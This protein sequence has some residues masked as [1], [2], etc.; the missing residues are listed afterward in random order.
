M[1]KGLIIKGLLLGI[2]SSILTSL[3]DSLYMFAPDIYVPAAYPF[4]LVFFNI[5]FWAL[6]GGLCGFLMWLF[7]GRNSNFQMKEPL[8]W[9][10]FFLAPFMLLYG[11]LG[12]A[13]TV[14]GSVLEKLPFVTPSYSFFWAALVLL[15]LMICL[16]KS[17]APLRFSPFSFLLEILLIILLFQ[18]SANI[19]QI[20][21]FSL[22]YASYEEFFKSIGLQRTG[23]L[24]ILYFAGLTGLFCF[25]GVAFFKIRPYFAR[26]NIPLSYK[27]TA[28]VL[29]ILIVLL[30][31]LVT[32]IY[33]TTGAARHT[34]SPASTEQRGAKTAAPVILI[35][36]DTVRADHL[37]LY[38]YN[39]ANKNLEAFSKDALVFDAC[40]ANSCWTLPSHAS[41]FTGLYPNEHGAHG[42]LNRKIIIGDFE[43]DPLPRPL[44]E[45]MITLAEIFKENGYQTMAVVANNIV[46]GKDMNMYQGFDVYECFGNIGDLNRKYPFRPIL[47]FI[48]YLANV[49]DFF[50]NTMRA[51]QIT[52]RC[53]Q[54]TAG[55]FSAPV[56]LFVNYMDAHEA[57]CP[58]RPYHS[59][60]CDMRFPHLWRLQM[61]F[62]KRMLKRYSQTTWDAYAKTQYDGAIAYLDDQLGR[63]F[64]HLKQSNLYDP[65]LIIVTSDH[66]ELFGE[67]GFRGHRT[68]MYEGVLR[69]PLIIKFPYSK[70][71][72]RE[73]KEI[74]L[75]DVFSTILS[76]CEIPMPGNVSG[77]PFGNSS[78]PAVAEYE[79]A[80]MGQHRVLYDGQYKYFFYE[81]ERPAELYDLRKDPSENDNL[82]ENQPAV[83][84]LLEEKLKKWVISHPPR[85][86]SKDSALSPETVDGLK[87]LGYIQ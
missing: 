16:A 67:H 18:F 17:V 85:Y 51:G 64:A 7:V 55:P 71:V 57:Y 44:D 59:Y 40:I 80:L 10:V 60:Y 70:Q 25:Y 14:V 5:S 38:G 3:F 8:Y 27:K 22:P 63:F 50:M 2:I 19:A 12:L 78:S 58:P 30:A 24:L 68:P 33:E 69:V 73:K 31:G 23:Y 42:D 84:K 65:A 11:F 28:A 56:F 13:E 62:R 81:R 66:G 37:S 35:V 43:G 87:A 39:V 53:K 82:A 9:T 61:D 45:K 15:F 46:L 54:L 36:L 48:S 74:Q 75:S 6:I 20:K 26:K 76:I 49:P 52:D 41:L 86:A 47:N 21:L 79:N 4:M 77:K 1:F 83:V 32:L 72:G 34:A 29:V